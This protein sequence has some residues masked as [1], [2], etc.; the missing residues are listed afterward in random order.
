MSKNVKVTKAE[1]AFNDLVSMLLC[2]HE[3]K[4]GAQMEVARH[5]MSTGFDK[6]GYSEEVYEYA[7]NFIENP[8][9][10]AETRYIQG[11]F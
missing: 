3:T 7:K 6:Y 8:P 11:Q 2:L 9:K 5:I 10:I 4:L 1:K